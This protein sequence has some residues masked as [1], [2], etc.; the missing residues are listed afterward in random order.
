MGRM[1]RS[2]ILLAALVLAVPAIAAD[3]PAVQS[4]QTQDA[5]T[6]GLPPNVLPPARRPPPVAVMSL[7]TS[8]WA[9]GGRIPDKYAQP[10]HD[11]SPPLAWNDVPDGT[12]SFVLIVHDLNA[13][14]PTDTPSFMHW[15]VWNIPKTARSL[16]EGVPQLEQLE[17]GTRQI[18]SSGPWYRGPAAPVTGPAHHYVFVLY[19]LNVQLA[20]PSEGQQLAPT[21]AA[22]E[23][24]MTGKIIG[25]G[26]LTGIFRRN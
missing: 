8:A 2:V 11:V 9:D 20:V 26:V 14:T 24:G 7:S 25:K 21:I 6:R 16:P 18:S 13:V 5:V 12:E 15:M 22:V 1:M 4:P 10:G 23:A 19:A 17:D 3:A